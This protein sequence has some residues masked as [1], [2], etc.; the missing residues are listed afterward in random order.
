MTMASVMTANQG[1]IDT[2]IGS[3]I[4][5]CYQQGRTD[6]PPVVPPEPARVEAMLA[7]EGRSSETI[8]ASHSTTGRECT[9]LAATTKTVVAPAEIRE[10]A[11]HAYTQAKAIC[12]G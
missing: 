1:Q 6:G 2:D 5:Y 8:I 3:A 12:A 10:R 4:D 7:M 11:S 9:V